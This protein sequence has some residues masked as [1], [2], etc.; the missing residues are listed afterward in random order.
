MRYEELLRMYE[1]EDHYW[2]FVGRRRLIRALVDRYAPGAR[3]ILDVGCGTGGTLDALAGL[4]DLAGADLSEDALGFCR[5]RGHKDLARCLAEALP[6]RDG[7]ADVVLGCDLL[8][9]ME[10]DAAGLA[11]MVRVARPGGVIIITVPA[12][13]WLWSEHDEA[14]SHLRRYSASDIR[15]IVEANGA[16]LVKLTYAVSLVFPI[17]VVFRILSRLRLRPMGKPHTQLMSLPPWANRILIW[18][19][20]LETWWVT[21]AGFPCG[22]TVVV[23]LRAPDESEAEQSVQAN[24]AAETGAAS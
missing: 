1:A 8:E 4:G 9:H 16:H 12:Y 10:N 5:S 20:D 23:V 19:H 2:W 18:L 15:R 22:T 7:A 3:R 6:F 17:V 24:T 13:Q 21:R 14:I 11:E